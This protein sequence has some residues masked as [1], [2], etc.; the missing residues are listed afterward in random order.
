MEIKKILASG[1]PLVISKISKQF[2]C[3]HGRATNLIKK[4]EEE[5]NSKKNKKVKHFLFV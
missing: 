2:H 3:S 1:E 5:L 4:C